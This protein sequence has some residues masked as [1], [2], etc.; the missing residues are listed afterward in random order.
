MAKTDPLRELFA[1]LAGRR[2]ADASAAARGVAAL[3]DKRGRHALAR[4]LYR[5]LDDTPASERASTAWSAPSAALAPL[6]ADVRLDDVVLSA[7]V[8][9]ELREIIEEHRSVEVLRARGLR[10]RRRLLFHGPPGSGKSLTARALGHELQLPVALV[11]FEALIGSWLGQTAQRLQEV[12]SFA[13]SVPSVVVLD[14]VDALSRSRGRVNEVGEMDRAV[15]A[16]LQNLEH[17]E[18]AGLIVAS[19]NVAAHLDAAIWRR[20]DLVV[21]FPKPSRAALERFA[22]E[23]AKKLELHLNGHVQRAAARWT[24][25]ADVDR[26]LTDEL[27]RRLLGRE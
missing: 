26:F 9:S 2:W 17:D 6:A 12:F 25:Y 16:L 7:R 5:V 8:K 13:R 18:P 14:E 22:A 21:E 4:D 24:S 20:F 10:P 27:R 11:R 3:E 19:T 15:V 1:A 23:R